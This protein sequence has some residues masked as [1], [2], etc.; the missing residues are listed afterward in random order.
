MAEYNKARIRWRDDDSGGS[1]DH[2][3]LAC[4]PLRFAT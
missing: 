1:V 2:F 4:E 3:Y